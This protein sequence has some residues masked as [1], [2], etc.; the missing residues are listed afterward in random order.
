MMYIIIMTI[1]ALILTV[2]FSYDEYKKGM[3]S[4]RNFKT[5][6]VCEGIALIGAVYLL[7]T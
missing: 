6:C 7:L 5:V 1:I 4:S 2:L 3:M